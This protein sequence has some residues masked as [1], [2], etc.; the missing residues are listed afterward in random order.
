MIS[1]FRD[2]YFFLSN[3]YSCTVPLGGRVYRNAEAAFQAGKCINDQ[4][5]D[6]FCSV[7]ASYA[8][9]FGRRVTL[10]PDW[11]EVK[12]AVMREV[13]IAKFMTNPTLAAWLLETG[14]EELVEGNTWGDTFWGANAQTGQGANHLGHLL[15]EVR[16]E[17]KS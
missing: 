1:K 4:D 9:T 2:E 17:L 14:D 13:L 10:R 15:M 11:E 7:D 8:K 12:L 16:H 3:F 5:K 6:V